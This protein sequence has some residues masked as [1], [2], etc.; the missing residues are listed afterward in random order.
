MK[1]IRQMQI[2]QKLRGHVHRTRKIG[3][4]ILKDRRRLAKDAKERGRRHA[5]FVI[6]M[7]RKCLHGMRRIAVGIIAVL[8]V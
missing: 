5:Q 7:L 2:G 8:D 1:G 3:G 6:K 4:R